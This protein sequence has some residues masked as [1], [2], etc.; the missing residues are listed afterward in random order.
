MNELELL[1]Q[2]SEI[3]AAFAGF[4]GIVAALSSN[5]TWNAL[6]VF[7]FQNLLLMSILS[8]FFSL[9]PL[10]LGEF[11]VGSGLVWQIPSVVFLMLLVVLL[12]DRGLRLAKILAASPADRLSRVVGITIV[13]MACFAILGQVLGLAE[14]LPNDAA[15]ISGVIALLVLSAM[16]F[17]L[18]SLTAIQ[19]RSES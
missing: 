18:L 14:Y 1:L 2:L 3:G 12:V 11:G 7:R 16:Q 5:I 17:A 9:F 4:S 13:V 15:Y 10:A 19:S 6:A 8:V